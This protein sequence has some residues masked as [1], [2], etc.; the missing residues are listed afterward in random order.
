MAGLLDP[1]S[2]RIHPPFAEALMGDHYGLLCNVDHFKFCRNLFAERK[3]CVRTFF[4]STARPLRCTVL[5]QA[6]DLQANQAS[7]RYPFWTEN[8]RRVHQSARS[9]VAP[10]KN[11]QG[12][13][14]AG[15]SFIINFRYLSENI[16]EKDILG[17]AQPF[18]RQLLCACAAWVHFFAYLFLHKQ[19]K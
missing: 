12:R 5:R 13:G 3:I 8:P 7:R 15:A 19:K 9:A 6:Q 1:P 2:L 17:A 4:I 18:F 11:F 16:F 14:D 10:R